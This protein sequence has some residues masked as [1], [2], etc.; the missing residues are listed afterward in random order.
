[1]RAALGSGRGRVL[2]QMLT[3]S[4]LL[5]AAGALLGLLLAWSGGRVLIAMRPDTL[6]RLEQFRIDGT[7]L[8]FTTGA[9]VVAALVFGLAPALKAVSSNLAE[10]LRDRGS[11]AGGVKGNKLRTALVV[12]E[13]ALS[14]V[15][16]VGTG[17][18]FRTFAK[19]QAVSPGFEPANV[20]TFNLPVPLFKYRDPAVR[21]DVFSRLQTR[22]GGLPS[23][24]SVG[25]T[26]P[27]PLAGGDQYAIG[28]YGL[29]ETTEEEWQSN[30]ADYRTI[31]PGYMDAMGIEIV[32]GRGLEL[33][34]NRAGALD[35]AVIDERLAQRLWPDGDPLGKELF[36]QRFNVQ[37]F[38]LD[39]VPLRVVGL[40]EPVRAQ[41][42]AAEG[43]ETIYY[44][45][46]FF[47]WFPLSFVVRTSG[48]PTGIIE[49]IRREVEAVDPDIPLSNVRLMNDYVDDAL[50]QTRF[51]LTLIGTFAGMALV[52]ASVGLYGVIA[53]SVRQRTREIGVR[54]AFGASNGA[55]VRLVVGQG[56]LLALGGLGVGLIGA[57]VATRLV[58]GLF[59]GVSSTDPL[60]LGTVSLVL[61]SVAIAASYIPARRATRIDPVVA[62][63]DE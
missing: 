50:A 33:A 6:P 26:S 59:Y 43:R 37:T 9:T 49:A 32:K 58:S 15:L 30:K 27:L 13:V 29:R 17:L 21:L 25:A 44:P 1:V 41:S 18:M 55:V 52:L 20:L 8:L 39:R 7:V 31:L 22:I 54:V 56:L 62:L 47:P 38:G 48:N 61:V 51:A 12:V 28:A 40:A 53:Y 36:I 60:T 4:S 19:L 45:Y 34:D 42:L 46:R 24:Q 35:V 3:E 5:A 16:L 63:R 10:A 11:D 23:V 2:R 57:F 14:L